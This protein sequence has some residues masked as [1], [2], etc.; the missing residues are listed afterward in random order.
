[1][2]V[3]I[4]ITGT[5]TDIGKTVITGL[6]GDYLH[7]QGI[8][9]G[10]LKLVS[11]GGELCDDCRYVHTQA[12][13]PVH[14][15]YHFPL[16][17][18]PH[19]AAEQYGRGVDV[20]KLDQAMNIM[21]DRHEVVLI[22]G[23]GGLLVP[24]TRALLLG[25][26]MATHDV[27]AILVARSGLGS[28]NH[29]LLTVEGLRQRGIPLLGIIFNDEQIYAEDNMLVVDNQRTIGDFSG[30]PVLGRMRRFEGWSEARQGFQVIGDN[31]LAGLDL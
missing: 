12:G 26:Y 24:L 21:E 16:P 5:D 2:A 23:A 30:V 20:R 8:D 19:L 1:M 29:T 3:K 6:L 7:A 25:D 18:S 10:Y 31:L 11:C 4:F 15:V 17:A 22:E 9:C 13:I 28:I 14:N 27:Q